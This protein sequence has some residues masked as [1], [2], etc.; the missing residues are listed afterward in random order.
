MTEINLYTG[1]WQS[2]LTPKPY[3]EPGMEFRVN[4]SPDAREWDDVQRA[5]PPGYSLQWSQGI[6]SEW[7]VYRVEKDPN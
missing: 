7:D 5:C 6:D 2:A 1:N 3:A 4:V